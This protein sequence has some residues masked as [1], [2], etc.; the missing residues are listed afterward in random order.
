MKKFNIPLTGFGVY[1]YVGKEEW[2]D[3]L[4]HRISHFPE[5]KVDNTLP[6]KGEGR[7]TFNTMWVEE[8]D[9]NLV[10]HELQHIKDFIF[11]EKGLETELEYRADIASYL[12]TA[13]VQWVLSEKKEV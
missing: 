5:L 2:E 7:S 11:F 1:I 13:V 6:N 3:Y 9:F 10:F 8:L 12:D 4:N